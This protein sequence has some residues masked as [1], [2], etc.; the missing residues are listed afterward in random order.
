MPSYRENSFDGYY[1]FS[2]YLGLFIDDL[3][4]GVLLPAVNT[5]YLITALLL[6]I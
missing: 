5:V 6:Q 3:F 2:D 4:E 1:Y